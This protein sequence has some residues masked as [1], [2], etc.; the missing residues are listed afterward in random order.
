MISSSKTTILKNVLHLSNDEI[1]ISVQYSFPMDLVKN[2]VTSVLS[3]SSLPLGN[4]EKNEAAIDLPDNNGEV[5]PLNRSAHA[6]NNYIAK[7]AEETE[8]KERNKT[9]QSLSLQVDHL[10]RLLTRLSKECD[11]QFVQVGRDLTIVSEDVKKLTNAVYSAG[12]LIQE[13]GNEKNSLKEIELL[14][15]D[16]FQALSE[17]REIINSNASQVTILVSDIFQCKRIREEINRI[18]S[19]FRI[20]RINIRIQCHARGLDENQFEGVSQDLEQLSKK[21]HHVTKQIL[22]DVNMGVKSLAKL[23]RNISGHLQHIDTVFQE[24]KKVVSRALHDINQLMHGTQTMINEADLKAKKIETR[25][26]E[27]IVGIQFH[28]SLNQRI[29]HII[30]ALQDTKELCFDDCNGVT[31][32][33]LGTCF[34]ILDLQIRQLNQLSR[35]INLVSERIDG[36]FVSIEDEV[37]GMNSILHDQQFREI[38][39]QQFLS[40]F[41]SSLEET[42]L[43]LETLLEQGEGMLEQVEETANDTRLITD[44]LNE[45]KENVSEIR[46]ETKVQAVNTIIM[47]SALGQKG[48]T[49]EVLAKEIQTLSNKSGVLAD[50]VEALS[51]AVNQTIEDFTATTSANRKH[52]NREEL[53]SSISSFKKTFSDVIEA[54]GEI[55]NRVEVS[56]NHIRATRSS[57]LFLGTLKTNLNS[58]IEHMNKIQDQ[59]LPWEACGAHDSEEIEKLKERY[60]MA[61]ERMIHALEQPENETDEVEEDIFF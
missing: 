46:D 33:Q 15:Q 5:A 45:L 21:L 52:I 19:L 48:K 57:L 31:E 39:P 24:A 37:N 30:R 51:L 35:E 17:E 60:S 4:R 32:K 47:A 44:N 14:V 50:D 41:F 22:S 1:E 36:D 40:G 20:V 28:D 23:Q 59:L 53:K 54:T 42:L 25:T 29:E 12:N 49:I 18:N 7:Q 10:V 3:F 56:G 6:E 11:P 38:S 2:L 43:Q 61:Q 34:I 58:I 26:G 16:V 8:I 13:D 9:A 55:S 27:V